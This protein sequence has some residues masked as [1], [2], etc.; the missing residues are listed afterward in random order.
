VALRGLQALFILF[1]PLLMAACRTQVLLI[2]SQETLVLG[3]K[4]IL[5]S[6]RMNCD[7]HCNAC[8]HEEN[9]MPVPCLG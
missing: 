4:F 3:K 2:T 8:A 5:A 1:A 9:G 7:L 6:A